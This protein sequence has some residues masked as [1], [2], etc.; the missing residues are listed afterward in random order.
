MGPSDRLVRA[1]AE[2]RA[3]LERQR[4]HLAREADGLRA[5]L[6]RIEAGLA[7]IDALTARLDDIAPRAGRR[8]G[9]SEI[10]RRTPAVGR[11]DRTPRG[12]DRRH[13]GGPP[14]LPSGATAA[15]S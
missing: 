11:R 1:V 2:E 4:A 15:K 3:T 13:G 7:E 5:S 6:R 9:D 8:R 14:A 12:T 10:G